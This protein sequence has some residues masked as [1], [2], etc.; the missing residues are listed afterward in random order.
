MRKAARGLARI[1]GA[2]A[3][4][5]LVAEIAG[6][7]AVGSATSD[8][9]GGGSS[10]GFDGGP[11][12]GF[13]GSSSSGPDSGSS[14][15]SS[16]GVDSGRSDDS[17]AG[18]DSGRSDDSGASGDSGR[19][20]D[21]GA[22]GDAG[23]GDDS[24]TAVDAGH[25]DDSGTTDAGPTVIF[26]A[27]CPTG[28]TYVE[29]LTSDPVARGTF[30]QLI[31]PY[32]Y[33]AASSTISLGAG[34]PNTQLWIGAR[35]SWTSYTLSVQVR[36]DTATAGGNGGVTFRME[37]TPASPANN[38]GQMY[39]AGIAT[40]QVILGVENGNWTELQGPAATFVVGTFYTL[41]VTANGSSL[42]MSVDGTPYV[43]SYTDGTFTFGSV[44]L[45][46]YASGMTYGSIRV[47]CN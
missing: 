13:D 23:H 17:G 16:G 21:S 41:Q 28:M 44:G 37:S 5:G 18:G 22:S 8:G 47:T 7:C 12:S 30:T 9:D 14:P 2:L 43:T 29:P 25:T 31:G 35:P 34:S 46:T 4:L 42:S 1:P 10:S 38:A 6:A 27:T 40:N 45:R 19:I 15:E 39:F 36:L 26:G 3:A 24:G 32:A 20:D 33:N 11:S